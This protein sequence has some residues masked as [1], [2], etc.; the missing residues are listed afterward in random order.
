MYQFFFRILVK[1][2]FLYTFSKNIQISN[3]MK[4]G[5]LGVGFSHVDGWTNRRH[6][7]NSRLS[8]FCERA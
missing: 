2:D 8:E 4:I 1:F 7:A 3:F 5:S 6:K